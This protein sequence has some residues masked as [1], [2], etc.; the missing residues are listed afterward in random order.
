MRVETHAETSLQ[1]VELVM[2]AISRLKRARESS[3][4]EGG[5]NPGYIRTLECDVDML[6]KDAYYRIMFFAAYQ[7]AR[8]GMDI[9]A[10]LNMSAEVYKSAIGAS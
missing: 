2:D 8:S 9:P 10:M 1:S 4:K 6:A 3:F 7:G 5:F